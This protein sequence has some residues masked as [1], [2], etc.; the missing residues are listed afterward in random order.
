MFCLLLKDILIGAMFEHTFGMRCVLLFLF[1]GFTQGGELV[2]LRFLIV[3][4]GLVKILTQSV[5]FHLKFDH[6]GRVIRLERNHKNGF[7]IGLYYFLNV[8]GIAFRIGF[9]EHSF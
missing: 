5:D 3:E 7:T 9:F 1:H 8:V 6:I 4:E 2:L